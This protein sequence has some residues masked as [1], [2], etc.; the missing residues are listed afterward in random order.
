MPK[1]DLL[2]GAVLA[3]I[4]AA[5]QHAWA[6]N[7]APGDAPSGYDTHDCA[8]DSF[9]GS[10]D[11]CSVS[12][13]TLYCDRFYGGTEVF[14][15]R[16]QGVVGDI[17]IWGTNDRVT[18][19]S[20]IA[21][22]SEKF[23]CNFAPATAN[24]LSWVQISTS[25]SQDDDVDFLPPQQP[26]IGL[27]GWVDVGGGENFVRT[28]G[29]DDIIFSG[30]GAD[31]VLSGFG[32]DDVSVGAGSDSVSGLHGDDTI[33]LGTGANDYAHGGDG[34][35]DITCGQTCSAYGGPGDD[36]IQGGTGADGLHGGD[37]NDEISGGGGNDVLHG[38]SG[39]D[40]CFGE[41]GTDTFVSCE[42][43]VQ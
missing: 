20:K 25:N 17:S 11:F 16:D 27:H 42:T 38:D 41:G 30:E 32:D 35:D 22:A 23:C 24:L 8:M 5:S 6:Q 33:D 31:T 39:T 2:T 10:I 19:S 37:G 29:G 4:L 21:G 7:C 13:F 15:S 3:S 9:G 14:L 28:S 12:G 18:T 26:G 40:Q 1:T 34:N 36:V 43:Q